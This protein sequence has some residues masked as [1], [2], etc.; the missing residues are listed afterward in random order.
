MIYAPGYGIGGLPGSGLGGRTPPGT[1]GAYL[2][3]SGLRRHALLPLTPANRGASRDMSVQRGAADVA[4][5][6]ASLSEPMPQL[7]GQPDI[8]L[9]CA[10]AR[11]ACLAGSRAPLF[12]A[13]IPAACVACR[14]AL[15]LAVDA[16]QDLSGRPV[17]AGCGRAACFWNVSGLGPR[18]RASFKAAP[19]RRRARWPGPAAFAWSMSCLTA[20]ATCLA[21]TSAARRR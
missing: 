5:G 21:P 20:W 19:R 6:S 16:R 7:A 18:A 12:P 10:T 15:C 4:S 1:T 13:M 11:I 8:Y 9:A 17:C 2:S 14:A 3:A